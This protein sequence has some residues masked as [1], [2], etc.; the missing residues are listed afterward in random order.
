MLVYQEFVEHASTSHRPM[1]VTTAPTVQTIK[2][3]GVRL[4]KIDIPKFDGNIM[5]WKTFW[6]PYSILKDSKPGL[7]DPEKLAYLCQVLKD[8]QAKDVIEGLSRSGDDYKDAVE[9]L[10]GRYD[11]PRLI[12]REHVRFIVKA[13]SLKEGSGGEIRRHHDVPS[14]HL[15]ALTAKDPYE[16]FVTALVELKLDQSTMFEWQRQSQDATDTPHYE[17][18]SKFLDLKA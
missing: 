10:H 7:S 2:E 15:R 17:R 1:A 5:N 4:P 12:Y 14:R 6:E 3:G 16:P 9:Y 11:K 8:R 18:L 13:S